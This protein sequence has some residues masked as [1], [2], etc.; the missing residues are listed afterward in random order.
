M[1]ILYGA[2]EGPRVCGTFYVDPAEELL[3]RQDL[4]ITIF[5]FSV[6]VIQY[7]KV[8]VPASEMEERLSHYP[9]HPIATLL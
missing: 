5:N 1:K 4:A 2:T 3:V 7:L 6:S 9:I 8:V